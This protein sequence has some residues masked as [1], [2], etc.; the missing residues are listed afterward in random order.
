LLAP[1]VFTRPAEFEGLAV[2]EILLSGNEGK[3]NEW[4]FEQSMLRTKARRPDLLDKF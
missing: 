3:I 1:P 4:R 2:P